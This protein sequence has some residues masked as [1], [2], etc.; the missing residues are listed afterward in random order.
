MGTSGGF[1]GNQGESGTDSDNQLLAGQ[2]R[3]QL[4]PG[5]HKASSTPGTLAQ[6]ASLLQDVPEQ[7]LQQVKERLVQHDV[8]AGSQQITL[9]LSPDT[10]GELKVNLNLQGQKLSVEIVTENRAVRDAIAQHTDALKESLAR[11]NITM[12]SFDVTTGGKGSGQG[13]NQNAWRELAKQQHQHQVW[14][15]PR[16]YQSAQAD[17]PSPSVTYQKQTGQS[18]LDIHY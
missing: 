14:A 1:G 4:S 8:K 9:T 2:M 3:G 16:S 12:E 10:L 6:P 13:Q 18:M 17:F 15:S 7:V 5:L 11:Q